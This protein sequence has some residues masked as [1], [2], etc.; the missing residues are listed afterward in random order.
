[1]RSSTNCFCGLAVLLTGSPQSSAFCVPA[2]LMVLDHFL[3]HMLL[4]SCVLLGTIG[5]VWVHACK[6]FEMWTLWTVN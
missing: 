1:M 3:D 6:A 2:F 4:W 5:A